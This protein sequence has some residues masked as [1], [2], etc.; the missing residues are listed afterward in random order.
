MKWRGR[1]ESGNVEDRRFSSGGRRGRGPSKISLI[2]IVLILSITYFTGGNL[3][4]GISN[5]INSTTGTTISQPNYVETAESKDLASFT[6]VVLSDTEDVWTDIFKDLGGKYNSPTLVMFNG[7][8]N[9]GC[10]Y[11]TSQTGPFYCPNDRKVYIDLDFY[12]ELKNRF[13]ASGDFAMAYVIAHEVGHHVQNEL[14]ITKQFF[15]HKAKLS[16]KEANRLT[17]KLELQADYLAGV[18]AKRIQN[19][20][21][22]EKG[23]IEEAI[24]AAS[25]IGDDTIQKR[26]SGRVVP[27]SFTHGTS[28]QRVKWFM[29]GYKAGDLSEWNTFN[30]KDL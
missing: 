9:S 14:G 25:S 26:S 5:V 28:E 29:K 19:K 18:F 10:G 6:K 23:D 17:V 15:E 4:D 11:A 2:G 12:K 21:Y 24:N 7:S 22:L 30:S 16:K 13:R 27:D 8:T 20:G 3:L 1:R